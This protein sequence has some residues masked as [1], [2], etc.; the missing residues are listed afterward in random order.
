MW[1]YLAGAAST[2]VLMAAGFFLVQ[3]MANPPGAV[4]AAPSAARAAV[5]TP[6]DDPLASPMRFADKGQPPTATELSKEEKRFNRY[7]KDKNGAVAKEEYFLSRRKAYA[8]LDVNGDGVLSFNEYAVKAL[9]KFTKADGDKSGTL[10][11]GEFSTTR[12]VRK[13]KPKMK[14]PPQRQPAAAPAEVGSGEDDNADT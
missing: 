1:R 14:C 7:D 2:I 6:A 9:T 10:N 13:E 3:S 4:P 8:K 5:P 12:V 11:R